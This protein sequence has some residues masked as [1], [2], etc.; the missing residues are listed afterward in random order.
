MAP[1]QNPCGEQF[2]QE[3]VVPLLN[4]RVPKERDI[5]QA[6]TLGA[7]SS[8]AFWRTWGV[9]LVAILIGGAVGGIVGGIL[10]HW[11]KLPLPPPT[12]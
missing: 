5:L 7:N 9:F 1:S 10:S 3:E 6:T 12:G 11:Q 4:N 2:S 8:R